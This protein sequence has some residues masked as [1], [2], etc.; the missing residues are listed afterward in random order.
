M[1]DVYKNPET[2]PQNEGLESRNTDMMDWGGVRMEPA[3]PA[4]NAT[5][6]NANEKGILETGLFRAM[7]LQETAELTSDHNSFRSDIYR[8]GA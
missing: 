2:T 6:S 7:G 8:V 4:G 1:S 3:G 5:L